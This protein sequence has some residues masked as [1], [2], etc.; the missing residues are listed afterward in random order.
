M[1]SHTPYTIGPHKSG[2]VIII[3]ITFI[4]FKLEMRKIS[5]KWRQLRKIFSKFSCMHFHAT[6]YKQNKYM[7]VIVRRKSPDSINRKD[8][9]QSRSFP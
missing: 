6:G 4:Y 1:I 5:S 8:D 7:N 2:L 9:F 3:T